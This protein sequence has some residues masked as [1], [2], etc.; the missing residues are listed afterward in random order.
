[1]ATG[2][3]KDSGRHTMRNCVSIW[4]IL[5]LNKEFRL[6]V[7]VPSNS[8]SLNRIVIFTA[9]LTT[10]RSRSIESTSAHANL[11]GQLK[12]STTERPMLIHQHG[13]ITE[14]QALNDVKTKAAVFSRRLIGSEACIGDLGLTGSIE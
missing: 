3:V 12:P 7:L 2:A 5:A 14:V 1:M 9:F 8:E 6:I 11:I 13:L 10:G 4:T